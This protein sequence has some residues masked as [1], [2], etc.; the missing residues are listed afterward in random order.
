M[1]ELPEVETTRRGIAA[2]LLDE[3]ISRVIIRNGKLRWPI[4]K[5]LNKHLSGHKINKVGRRAKYLL[6]YTDHGCLILHLGMSGSLCI[7]NGRVPPKKHDHVDF[8]FS[9]GIRLRFR[10]P[11]RF[12]SIH[13]TRNDPLQHK[14]LANLGPEPLGDEFNGPY[15]FDRSRNRTR[16]VKTF[17]MDSRIVVGVGNIYA[18]EALFMSGIFPRRQ[19]GRVSRARYVRLS[20]AI[21]GVLRQA[22]EKG[23]TTL[24]DFSTGE[25]RPGYFQQELQAYGRHGEPCLQCGT[26]IRQVRFGQRSSYYCPVCQR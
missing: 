13:W 21:K 9:S 14:L 23:G 1:P 11:R 2:Y 22:L 19:A 6:F 20:S 25:G 10:D 3:T 16:A 7:T 4:P 17:I 8:V 12:G 26:P 24:R 15:L 5:T 18:N